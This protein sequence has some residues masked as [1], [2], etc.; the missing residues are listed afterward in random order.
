M[1][2]AL[3]SLFNSIKNGIND[4]LEADL[5]G[6]DTVSN[7]PVGLMRSGDES[8]RFHLGSDGKCRA[9]IEEYGFGITANCTFWFESPD[10]SY[11]VRITSTGGTDFH[12]QPNIKIH[13]RL[14][15]KLETKI[16][17]KTKVTVEGSASVKNT[18]GVGKIA[19]SF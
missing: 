7:A 18:D 3:K 1:E 13:Q 19:Y 8:F 14:D 2:R 16:I 4:T 15:F 10:A 12:S 5:K 11:S 6:T 9:E 17:G